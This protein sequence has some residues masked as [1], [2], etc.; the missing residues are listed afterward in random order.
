MEEVRAP[1]RVRKIGRRLTLG[2]LIGLV[3]G[4]FVL[5]TLTAFHA[6]GARKTAAQSQGTPREGMTERR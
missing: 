4:G 2:G 6:G 1:D 3:L 5:A